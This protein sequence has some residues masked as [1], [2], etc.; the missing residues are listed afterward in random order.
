MERPTSFFTQQYLWSSLASAQ[1]SRFTGASFDQ[2]T[3]FFHPRPKRPFN[4]QKIKLG[5]LEQVQMR[6]STNMKPE[7]LPAHHFHALMERAFDYFP[8]DCDTRYI[9]EIYSV[10][11]HLRYE[12][13]L[14]V[15]EEEIDLDLPPLAH[16]AFA[17]GYAGPNISPTTQLEALL[18]EHAHERNNLVEEDVTEPSIHH[19]VSPSP[20]PTLDT[21]VHQPGMRRFVGIPRQVL[22]RSSG[23]V[24]ESFEARALVAE[25]N[26]EAS[27]QP[28][29]CATT[30]QHITL[31]AAAPVPEFSD[32]LEA[33]DAAE[34]VNDVDENRVRQDKGLPL[35]EEAPEQSK[36]A[37]RRQRHRDRQAAPCD[38]AVVGDIQNP[39]GQASLKNPAEQ[40]KLSKSAARRQRKRRQQIE[41][42]AAI[43]FALRED[44]KYAENESAW[45]GLSSIHEENSGV[46][47]VETPMGQAFL[48]ARSLALPDPRWAP[49]TIE[50]WLDEV[51]EDAPD[52]HDNIPES[53][54]E[55]PEQDARI[56]EGIASGG[57]RATL[58]EGVPEEDLFLRQY[59]E[60]AAHEKHWDALS[61]LHEEEGNNS[62]Q[63]S[64]TTNEAVVK[65]AEVAGASES[66]DNLEGEEANQAFF[67]TAAPRSKTPQPSVVVV[68]EN[69]R[70][71]LQSPDPG[72]SHLLAV[73][74][75][76]I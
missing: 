41:L 21:A 6:S 17:C 19:T 51:D 5:P 33:V 55:H 60:Y 28:A 36:R 20:Q 64:E 37:A 8:P 62:D 35:L 14:A 30:Y 1:H 49:E 42:D 59:P 18:D 48:Q 44:A 43:S 66:N 69:A 75:F 45:D 4:P 54:E 12:Y 40:P 2:D 3:F 27:R 67:D 46:S 63:G 71:S 13:G 31:Q 26:F 74:S 9:P 68:I 25:M 23:P 76:C 11:L 32:V 10:L 38:T 65:V 73:D 50:C 7:D 70:T 58:V 16:E 22:L 57:T 53:D 56:A 72:R 47:P 24:R 52:A 15:L 39:T 29:R 61:S 34:F